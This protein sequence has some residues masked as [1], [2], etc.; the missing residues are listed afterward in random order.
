VLIALIPAYNPIENLPGYISEL[1]NKKIFSKVV[2]VNDGST[3]D[4]DPIFSILKH[5]A[6]VVIL[7][8]AINRGK[9]AALKTG[10]NYIACEFPNIVGVV[11]IDADGQHSIEDACNIAQALC[12]R[13]Q[14]LIVGV[15]NFKGQVP[16]RSLLGNTLTRY[17][18][19]IVAGIKLTDTQSGLRGI[20]IKLIA[21]LLRI[22]ANAYEFELDMLIA[23]NQHGFKI[24]ELPV[25]TI[26]LNGNTRSSF[27]PLW[28]SLRIYFVLFRFSI[29]AILSAILDYGIF[30]LIYF[31]IA[32][33]VM[34]ALICGRV[35]SVTFNY[36]NVRHYAFRSHESH[37]HTL[38]KYLAL[39]LVSG[40]IA[41][42]LIVGMMDL[43]S[44]HVVWAKVV[45][46]FVM[47][48]INF[49]IQRDFIFRRPKL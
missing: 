30:M 31:L 40:L 37:I 17:T 39:A 4:Y 24:E 44:W 35:V 23:A 1:L 15:R 49:L 36:L 16:F 3:Q 12:A 21:T 19:R 2:V 48:I 20:P 32:H 10:L 26:Y 14:H 43:L 25:Q 34:A 7:K 41:Y 27:R 28:D 29:I 38:P 11:T 47:F 46:E 22:E 45:A 6:D 33:N 8:H 5:S 9:G 13:P 42:A 18:L